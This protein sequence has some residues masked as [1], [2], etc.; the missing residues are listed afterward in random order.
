MKS[1]VIGFIGFGEAAFAISSGLLEEKKVVTIYAYDV[2]R[3]HPTVGQVIRERAAALGVPLVASLEELCDKA[4]YLFCAASAKVAEAIA[5]DVQ[6]FLRPDHYYIDMNAASPMTMERVAA[7]IAETGVAFIDAAVM[8]SVPPKKHKVAIYVSGSE[9]RRF[10]EAANGW[11]MNMMFISETPGSS[12]AIKMFRSIFMKGL[13]VL[14]LETLH[15]SRTYGVEETVLASLNE[16]LTVRPLHETT[17]L[18]LPRTAIHTERRVAEMKE[19]VS[20]LDMLGI[21]A[22]MSEAVKAKL[23]W[24]ADQ[25]IREQ[26]NGQPPKSY[27]QL[28]TMLKK[29]EK[30]ES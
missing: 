27:D 12:S 5:K 11:G 13:S 6:P 30:K 8:D 28:L 25:R 7:H 29:E 26:W 23:Q 16:S 18:L 24:L 9:A 15:A 17:D 3:D 2:N 10:T 4:V 22:T 20:T 1:P 21:D 14:L 19:V